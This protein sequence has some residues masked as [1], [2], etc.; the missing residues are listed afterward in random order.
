M[1][2][3]LCSGGSGLVVMGDSDWNFSGVTWACAKAFGYGRN[4]SFV[5]GKGL[6]SVSVV[7]G[8]DT[9]DEMIL[10]SGSFGARGRDTSNEIVANSGSCL[11]YTSRCV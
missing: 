7:R 4:S 2:F 9:S 11:L 6:S 5:A 10:S 3:C 1:A 8:R